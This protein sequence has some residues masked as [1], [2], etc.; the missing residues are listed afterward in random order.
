MD[1]AWTDQM[2]ADICHN[3]QMVVWTG[4]VSSAIG[5]LIREDLSYDDGV[6]LHAA[7]ASEIR[8]IV[9]IALERAKA[10]EMAELLAKSVA[11]NDRLMVA[12]H[13]LPEEALGYG[14]DEDGTWPLRNELLQAVRIHRRDSQVL[15]QSLRSE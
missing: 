4:E 13:R 11:L 2:L 10:P 14:E 6:A 7:I 8:K 5:D 9:A 15:L 1:D 12:I 3:D